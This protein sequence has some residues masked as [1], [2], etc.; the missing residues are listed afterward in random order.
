MRYT[1]TFQNVSQ[2]IDIL[3][4]RGLVISDKQRAK[5][6]LERIGYY[7]LS[8][9]AYPFKVANHEILNGKRST[10]IGEKFKTGAEF[11]HIVDLYIFDKKLRLITL[12]AVERV[13]IGLRASIALSIGPYGAWAHRE[14]DFLDGKFSKRINPE[15]GK[16][17]HKVWLA[18]IDKSFD[19][20]KEE[21]AKHFRTKY[22]DDFPP[23]WISTEVWDFGALS[24]F[25]S[26]LKFDD[27]RAIAAK[28]EISDPSIMQSWFRSINY[29]RNICAH[30]S[31]FWN[32][33]LV[34]QCKFPSKGKIE[35]LDHLSENHSI[36]TRIYGT[37]AAI[38]YL[39]RTINP[40]TTW[41]SRLHSVLCEFP[42]A[43]G[44]SLRHS[45]FPDN[46]QEL[47]L[48]KM[49]DNIKI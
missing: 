1:K 2:Q 34:N 19:R 21:F 18:D 20:S 48:W 41:S 23:L 4:A 12:D 47:P 38:R 10:T 5:A 17:P 37:L 49:P 3:E 32:R 28:Y 31:R 36:Q 7:R 43:P 24:K 6:Y 45:G 15:N 8:G 14:A 11:K 33:P 9:Y 40:T 16:T 13:E 44:I 25:Y 30:H 42:A 46:W 39:L 27:Q 29:V 35:L 22:P 26:G